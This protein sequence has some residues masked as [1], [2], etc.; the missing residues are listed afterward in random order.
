M[1]GSF[2]DIPAELHGKFTHVITQE[3]LVHVHEELSKSF[4]EIK[5][6]LAP[7]CIAVLN[8]YVGCDGQVSDKTKNTVYS[9]LGFKML[10][11]HVAWRRTAEDAGF[12][13]EHYENLDKHVS[14]A[15]A[16]LSELAAKHDFKTSTGD[17][18]AD[19]YAGSCEAAK[20]RE[21]GLNLA[22]LSVGN[23]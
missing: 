3:S 20:K 9:R 17:R 22:V 5:K 1:V 23:F 13:F 8:E 10:L 6:V 14:H 15:Y 12:I 21:I 16:Q 19:N 7:G 4:Q 2:T 18:L 11:G